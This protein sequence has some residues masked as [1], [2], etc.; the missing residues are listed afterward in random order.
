MH[1]KS[2]LG[3]LF[4]LFHWLLFIFVAI[5]SCFQSLWLEKIE[6]FL[7]H[8]NRLLQQHAVARDSRWRCFREILFYPEQCTV[9]SDFDYRWKCDAASQRDLC[10]S[11]ETELQI[12]WL[13]GCTGRLLF[14]SLFLLLFLFRCVW[15]D[16]QRQNQ[17]SHWR[18]KRVKRETERKE[19]ERKRRWRKSAEES[20]LNQ[21]LFFCDSSCKTGKNSFFT[22]LSF[23]ELLS[24]CYYRCHWSLIGNMT[25]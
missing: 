2:H 5:F 4:L 19:I 14:L 12:N 21:R 16:I 17:W 23:R 8:C 20:H 10:V 9:L 22:S 7:L 18:E 13:P 15:C 25:S 1:R 3:C 6:D 11:L 24:C